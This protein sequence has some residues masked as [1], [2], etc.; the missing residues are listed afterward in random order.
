MWKLV[1][2]PIAVGLLALQISA[3]PTISNHGGLGNQVT[4]S[5]LSAASSSTAVAAIQLEK[6]AK[7]ALG[8][9]SENL[10]QQNT[11]HKKKPCT[12]NELH[13]RRNWRS[14]SRRQK[15]EFVNAL[16]CL[17]SKP[18]RT[19][20]HLAAG[21]KT[22]YDDFVATHINQTLQIHYTVC[23]SPLQSSISEFNKKQGHIPSLASV[24]YLRV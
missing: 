19:P 12:K 17:Q 8:V 1:F 10:V 16:L 7:I 18:A 2:H 20:S 22:R 9:A 4:F 23:Q 21:A 6:L 13:I 11:P 14:F 15:K 5:S 24:F 3:S